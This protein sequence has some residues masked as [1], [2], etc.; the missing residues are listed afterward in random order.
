MNTNQ[1]NQAFTMLIESIKIR[2]ENKPSKDNDI[3]LSFL[4]NHAKQIKHGLIKLPKETMTKIID[5]QNNGAKPGSDDFLAVKVNVKI[6]RFLSAIGQGL[7][8]PIDSYSQS[9][10]K[11]L[12]ELEKGLKNESL[13]ATM[14]RKLIDEE[15]IMLGVKNHHNC[16]V[17]T[18]STQT[19]STREALRFMGAVTCVKR[20]K[21]GEMGFN[22]SPLAKTIQNLF[23]EKLKIETTEV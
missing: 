10:I 22:D 12:I 3:S 19:S 14:C 2:N 4:D 16:N 8:T 5:C 13:R 15:Q 18:A 1:A 9:I 11:T 7:K 23:G 17:S 20:Q 6:V 21:G